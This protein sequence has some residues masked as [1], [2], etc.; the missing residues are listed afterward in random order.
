MF[1]SRR[2][3]FSY[4]LGVEDDEEEEVAA[5]LLLTLLLLPVFSELELSNS[6]VELESIEMVIWV[7]SFFA[8][9]LWVF[10]LVG[11][12]RVVYGICDVFSLLLGFHFVVR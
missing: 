10:N 1:Q 5:E 11:S 8:C 12:C 3:W 6:G 9:L 4:R 2:F 7:F